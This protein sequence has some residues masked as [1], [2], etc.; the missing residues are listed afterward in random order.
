MKQFLTWTFVIVGWLSVL[1]GSIFIFKNEV[2]ILNFEEGKREI[3]RQVRGSVTEEIELD[4]MY[5]QDEFTGLELKPNAQIHHTMT[6]GSQRIFDVVY[7]IDA[8]GL[9]KTS[10]VPANQFLAL[11]GCSMV[12]G[13]GSSDSDT[14]SQRIADKV[15]DYEIY[16]FGV[17]GAGT[18]Y[19][20]AKIEK[21]DFSEVLKKRKG[22]FIYVYIDNHLERSIGTVDWMYKP[23]MP[24]Y[25]WTGKELVRQGSFES[26]RPIKTFFSKAVRTSWLGKFINFENL[27]S[28][29]DDDRSLI[30]NMIE[31]AKTKLLANYPE[32]RFLVLFHPQGSERDRAHLQN[33]LNY[34]NVESIYWPYPQEPG[35]TQPGGNLFSIPIDGHPNRMAN[36]YLS[37]QILNYL[38][39]SQKK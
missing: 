13:I 19:F 11:F 37:D 20:L 39:I 15:Q 7:K 17:P 6:D 34:K 24:H 32:S 22:T 26:S 27:K 30:C 10:S 12:F 38:R 16:N 8:K 18:N 3:K 33:C 5:V 28:I 23:F 4:S 31:L 1:I 2:F 29:N 9:R 14:L 21:N 35:I 36:E 25:E